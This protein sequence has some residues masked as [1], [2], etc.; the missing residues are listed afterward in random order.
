MSESDRLGECSHWIDWEFVR[1][2]PTPARS[3][4]SVFSS[5]LLAYLFRTPN[6][7]SRW[8]VSNAVRAHLQLGGKTD[9]Q[10]T[11]P[12]LI[13][14][15]GVEPDTVGQL[16]DRF[17]DLLESEHELVRVS[18]HWALGYLETDVAAVIEDRRLH[19]DSKQ[20]CNR[21]A[22][23]LVEKKSGQASAAGSDRF[24]RG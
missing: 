16:T 9:V 1:R 19:D 4:K 12:N 15:D 10:P 13:V 24:D 7:F 8:W 2:E 17:V 22:W 3:S 11:G 5:T 18:T 21:A 23:G 14:V 6:S 20:V